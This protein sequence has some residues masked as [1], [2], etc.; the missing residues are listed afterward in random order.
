MD[1]D[2]QSS[3]SSSDSEVDL[4]ET[5]SI[6]S[7]VD[8]DDEDDDEDDEDDEPASDVEVMSD[9]LPA[10]TATTKKRGRPKQAPGAKKGKQAQ[11]KPSSSLDADMDEEI[12]QKI[13]RNEIVVD[14]SDEEEE[15]DDAEYQKL[16]HSVFAD[17]VTQPF[18][19]Y[20]R[21]GKEEIEM[22]TTI[23]RD[24]ENNICDPTHTTLP[25]LTNYERTR[26]LSVRV[27]QLDS[28]AIPLISVTP[29]MKYTNYNIAIQELEHKKLSFI[30]QRPLP[31]N[32]CEY[33]KV[34]DLELI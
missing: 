10:T 5:A 19:V 26:I 34:E 23:H 30:I 18:T 8:E 17:S 24:K 11:A 33:W 22:L 7:I 20:E 4:I 13:Q 6:A 28:G 16:A 12:Y 21:P 29:E 9:I 2:D 31:D 15:N 32:R 3:N 14:S 27:A 25:W 1:D